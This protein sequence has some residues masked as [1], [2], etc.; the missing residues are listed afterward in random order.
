MLL[1]AITTAFAAYAQQKGG[2]EDTTQH[3]TVYSCPMHPDVT[4]NKPGKCPKCGVDLTLSKKEQ[5]K[6]EVTKSYA[7]PA[8]PDVISNKTGTCPKCGKTLLPSKKEQ[9]KMEVMKYTCPMH[10]D[11][12]S[13]KPGTCP[14]CGMKLAEKKPETN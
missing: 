10:P 7:C 8:H 11:V 5:M 3:I 9:M 13:S 2:R 4:S 14:K 6:M 1:I 12:V